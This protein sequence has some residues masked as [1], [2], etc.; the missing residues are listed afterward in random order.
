MTRQGIADVEVHI[1]HDGDG[2]QSF[3]D[4]MSVFVRTLRETHGL[5]REWKDGVG[6]GFVHGNWALDNSRP[7][8]RWCGLNDE[9]TLLKQLGCYADFTLPSA[10]DPCQTGPVNVIYRA[11]DDPTR[12]RSHSSGRKVR[13]GLPEWGDLTLIPG[14]LGLSW[15][16]RPIWKPRLETGEIAGTERPS[17]ATARSWLRLAPRIGDHGFIKLFGH[18]AQERNGLPLLKGGL[19]TLFTS[20][21]SECE[22]IGATLRYVSAWELFR[23]VESLRT[24]TLL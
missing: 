9:I 10:P 23:A 21:E 6:F 19:D 8:G 20:L 18:G 17:A 5:L 24:N 7:D 15:K 1:H 2:R 16:G 12:P 14:P 13:I 22:A 11:K 3:V 4:R